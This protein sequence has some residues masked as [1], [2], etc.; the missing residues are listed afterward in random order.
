MTGAFFAALWEALPA[1]A[2][3]LVHS[4]WQG[5]LL[6]VAAALSLRAAARASAAFRHNLAMAF[7][8]AMAVVPALQFLHFWLQADALIN[9]GL[10][11]AISTPQF[12]AMGIVFFQGSSPLAVVTVLIWLSGAS[13]MLMRHA[14]GL[15]AVAAMERSPSKNL[16]PLWRR[17]VVELQGALGIVHAVAVRLSGEVL[18]PCATH[19][20]RPVIWL[21]A[22][23]LAR[24]PVEQIEALLAHEL[25][26]IARRDW[27]WNGVQCMIEALLFFHPAV[28]WLSRR[29]RQERE[30]ACDD[31]AV[32]VC[33]DEIVLAE[34]LVAL[35][36]GRQSV[37]RLSL[38][39]GGGSLLQ[40]VSRLL[41]R[42]PSRGR[43]GALAV[44][45]ALTVTGFLL[46]A[47]FGIAGGGSPDLHM[48]SSTSG[49]LGPGDYREITAQSDGRRR[50]YRASIDA[51]GRLT[52]VYRENGQVRPIDQRVRDWLA[53]VSRQ[54]IEPPP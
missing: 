25:A 49:A 11:Q 6:A 48:V 3:A 45:G 47:Q 32:A 22:S 19:L 28:W 52:E 1:L 31:L 42:P 14:G 50:F 35:E 26:H 23:L 18:A 30:H 12:G 8:L 2:A 37:P 24:V 21:P 39:A 20:L 29:I 36:R 40:R 46:I 33:G 34:A 53:E 44:I 17:R 51:Q 27:L 54:S 43:W 41:S 38:G 13:L 7:L 5:A 4:I 15:R 10:W 16:P 9:D